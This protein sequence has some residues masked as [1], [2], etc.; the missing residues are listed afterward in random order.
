MTTPNSLLAKFKNSL[1]RVFSVNV[2]IPLFFLWQVKLVKKSMCYQYIGRGTANTWSIYFHMFIQEIYVI[3]TSCHLLLTLSSQPI[4]IVEM[5]LI[6][7]LYV[8]VNLLFAITSFP[9]TMKPL[10]ALLFLIFLPKLKVFQCQVPEYLWKV[11][12]ILGFDFIIQ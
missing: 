4:A 3:G 1:I 6:W 2:G 7:L 5:S 8:M 11:R 10:Q 12:Y 9:Q